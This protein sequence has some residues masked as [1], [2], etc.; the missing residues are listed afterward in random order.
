LA[1]IKHL[2]D[3]L[4]ID[5][6]GEITRLTY[7][8]DGSPQLITSNDLKDGLDISWVS[9]MVD[10]SFLRL[11]H[12]LTQFDYMTVSCK[13]TS[14]IR[15]QFRSSDRDCLQ[16]TDYLLN[17]TSARPP[18]SCLTLGSFGC[19][20]VNDELLSSYNVSANERTYKDLVVLNDGT[21]MS[22]TDD[23]KECFEG[24]DNF[25]YFIINVK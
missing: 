22:F 3:Y 4:V 21:R 1:V 14:G 11:L 15:Y 7:V 18:C 8:K 20:D 13:S 16:H 17:H 23:Y 10:G 19:G 24:K 9:R 5:F 6:L 2:L 25:E 12:K